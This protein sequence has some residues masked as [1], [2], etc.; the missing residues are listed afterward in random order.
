MTVLDG[1]RQDL[2]YAIR[3]LR[4]SP[5]FAAVAVLTLALGIGANA[6]I[7]SV[8]DGL[9]LRPPPQVS[10]PDRLVWIYTSD[11][12]GPPYGA[13][14][15]PD[16]EAF[17]DRT[18][19]LSGAAAFSPRPVNLV[20]GGRTMRLMSEMV[21]DDYFDVLGVR[22]ERGRG[23]RREE[24]E[25]PTPVAVIGHGLWQRRFGGDPGIIGKP[26]HLN[27]G[28]FTVVG[29]APPEYRGS[30]RGL[31]V[32]VWVPFRAQPLLTG[33]QDYVGHRSNR[34]LFV[35]GRL[36]PG[37]TPARAQAGFRVVAARL[38]EAYP[39]SW[40]DAHDEGRRITVVPERLSR[41]PMMIRGTAVRL[42]ALLMGVVGLVLLL[43]CA[44][45][46]NLLLAR[47][48]G[49]SRELAVRRSLGAGRA[50]LVRQLLTESLLL[51][52]LG[53]GAGLLLAVWGVRLF[54]AL[55]PPLPVPLQFDVSPDWR[56][57]AF[58]AGI[59]L[60][61]AL[62][63]GLAP[64]LRASRADPASSLKESRAA[65]TGRKLTLQNALV[66]AQVTVSLVLLVGAGLFLRSLAAA[67]GV[68]VG[69]DPR[70]VLVAGV[71]LTTQGY[72][73]PE[74]L[75]FYRTLE[76]RLR[77]LPGVTGV[78]LGSA[79]PL[80]GTS[81]R[82]GT[83]VEG[84]EPKK[85]ED[86]EFHFAVVGP[87]YFRVL[88]IPLLRGRSF[89]DRDRAGAPSAAVVNEA[90]ARRFWPGEDAVGKRLTY[91]Y[92]LEDL[93]VVGVVPTA[94]YGSLREDPTPFLYLPFLQT[95]HAVKVHVRTRGDPAALI[96]EVRRVVHDVDPDLPITTLQPMR[97]LMAASLLPQRVGA[98]ILTLFAVLAL[99]LAAVGLYGVLAYVVS[100]RTRELGIR[101][102]LG[103][104]RGMILRLVIRRGL[105]ITAVG[106]VLGLGLS[107]LFGRIASRFLFGVSPV[108]PVAFGG[109]SAVL[110]LA[111]LLASWLPARRAASVEPAAALR[112]E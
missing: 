107:A 22:P 3:Q 112:E 84:Y 31:R 45:V 42:A 24:G 80:D 9:F 35:I 76:G 91:S 63:F 4:R 40:T 106:L 98:S 61:T 26:I 51:G 38:H 79:V 87:D 49:R 86:M 5:G 18:D 95:P 44:N 34:G 64:A 13:S 102:A 74:K 55:L 93:T 70:G 17:R 15:Y 81:S 104:D 88:H 66:V 37:V 85:G 23:F 53:G 69:L 46:A 105:G 25:S 54:P 11:F 33:S 36:R 99:A 90:F 110:A 14:S 21:S 32:D 78:A 109:V 58:A 29:V 6:A 101:M 30:L 72:T 108:D 52:A 82:T 19:L 43:C 56:V 48:A 16:F 12:S 73:D 96:P 50:R 62:L 100:R 75:E 89:T 77:R 41:V 8:V 60:G 68:D 71:D 111:A 7:F 83:G 20:E 28:T 57:L 10:H 103:A 1:V 92:D 27:G 94:R 67:R 59:S 39:D 2:R 47:A 97:K 65:G